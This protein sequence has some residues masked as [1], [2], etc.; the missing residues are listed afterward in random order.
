MGPDH[1][2]HCPWAHHHHSLNLSFPVCPRRVGL[3]TLQK[4]GM[5]AVAVCPWE[6]SLT[7]LSL[8]FFVQ[9]DEIMTIALPHPQ[10]HSGTQVKSVNGMSFIHSI[11]LPCAFPRCFEKSEP[12]S[13]FQLLCVFMCAEVTPLCLPVEWVHDPHSVL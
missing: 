7:F 13:T 2:G 1:S 5:Q 12:S 11:S 10:G 8:C 6:S 9:K 4:L 3:S